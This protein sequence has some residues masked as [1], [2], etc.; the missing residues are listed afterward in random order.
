M[1]PNYVKIF[2]TTLRDGEQSPGFSMN[3]EEKVRLALQLERLGVDVMEA[4][5]PAASPDDFAAVERIAKAIK[6]VEVCGLARAIES[7]IRT[8]WEA[9]KEAK[10]PRI[11]TFIATSPV[12]M[13]YKLK[14]SPVQ[15]KQ[16]AIEA[17][18]LAKSLCDRVDFSPEDGGRS[19]RDFLVE[20]L[21][22]VIKA[23]ADTLNIPDTVGYLTPEEFEDLMRYLI[24]NTPGADSVIWS[25]HC[26]DDLGLGVANSL[27]GVRA[28]ARQIE[29]TIN[30]IGERAGN[31]SLEEVVMALQTRSDF[32]ELEHGIDSTEIYRTSQLLEQIT[33]Q[34]V[35]PNKAI[36]GKNAFAHESGIHQHGMLANP[37]TYEIMTPESVGVDKTN[38]VL[39]KHSG[40]A[41]LAARLQD[42]GYQLEPEQLN[43][44]FTDFKALADKKKDIA[45]SDLAILVHGEMAEANQTWSLVH[46]ELG[47]GD[48]KQPFAAL[49]LKNHDTG[50]IL[51][52]KA[53]GDGMV[54]AAY[55]CIKQLCGDHGTLTEFKMDAVTA[56]ID[57]QAVVN[58]RLEQPDGHVV[59]GRAGDTDI[60]K[61]AI[62]AYL[63]AVNRYNK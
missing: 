19:D 3:T 38:I 51:A 27:A 5:F 48:A 9:I 22:A 7:D 4:G 53:D 44:I 17:V 61:A 24:K 28:G 37:E 21:G 30:G 1:K 34:K 43:E 52:A 25:T 10:M 29:C 63:E 16:M 12:H 35:Q 56:G 39:G 47:S 50:E 42:M 45:D 59:T 41:A 23:G 55:T 26:H 2:D 36:V 11:H 14:K 18:T 31:A 49:H 13:E 32:Y 62:M 20:V 54:D 15:V 60:V 57:A 46:H 40:R 8:T 58:V 33:G 6:T